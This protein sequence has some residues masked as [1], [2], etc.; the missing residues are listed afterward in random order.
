MYLPFLSLT[1]YPQILRT[2][3]YFY[4]S[5]TLTALYPAAT[6]AEKKGYL[7]ILKKN[8]KKLKKWSDHCPEN[9]LHKYLLVSAEIAGIQGKEYRALAFYVRAITS[10]RENEYTQNEA[11]AGEL[12]A[13]FYLQRGQ[14]SLA[15]AHIMDAY[16]GFP[17]WGAN[18]KADA[19]EEEYGNLVAKV[20]VAKGDR[21]TTTSTYM[22]SRGSESLDITSVI[23]VSQAIL[24]EINL[25]KLLRTLMKIVIENASARRGILILEREGRLYVE[26]EGNADNGEPEVLQ[27]VPAEA[28][29][30]LPLSIVNYVAR[31]RENVVLDD[32]TAEGM[33]TKDNYVIESGQKSI[34]CMAVI[35]QGSLTGLLYLE[36]NLATKAFTPKRL[37]LLKILTGCG[38]S[39]LATAYGPRALAMLKDAKIEGAPFQILLLDCRM[40]TMDGFSVAENIKNDPELAGVTIMMLTSDNRVGDSARARE[41]GITAYIVKPVKRSE[42][43]N[44]ISLAIGNAQI[45]AQKP[46]SEDMS[47]GQKGISS[48]NVLLVEDYEYNRIVI[49]SYLHNVNSI[50]VAENGL[51]AVDKF[52]SKK[53]DLVFMDMQMPEMDGYTATREIRK[54]EKEMGL[55]PTPIIA[56]TAHALKENMQKSLDTGCD[57]HLT[58]PIKKKVLLASIQKFVSVQGHIDA[59]SEEVPAVHAEEV[60]A[61]ETAGQNVVMVI[62]DFQEIVP[63]FLNS[64]RQDIIAMTEALRDNNYKKI[65]ELGHRIKGAGGG[66]GFHHISEIARSL[67]KQA[68]EGNAEEIQRQLKEFSSYLDSLHIVYKGD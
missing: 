48:L 50:D 31:T 55:R 35:H 28:N 30:T 4:Y 34:L 13:K 59:A 25:D 11:V 42:L 10:A 39:V 51:I 22:S 53:Y 27:S 24:G 58:K 66:Y 68:E 9:F 29:N 57:D 14:E 7:K 32:A 12:L 54:Y 41:L 15:R 36:N 16:Y 21:D 62:P 63:S 49:Q 46:S 56:L 5:L 44:T 19:L 43:L 38:A 33:F 23:K 8:C 52:K 64:V 37:E 2:S 17:G 65:V 45:S 18:A 6:A 20:P 60:G 26:A 3:H 67:E 40:P 47:V 1:N 61:T